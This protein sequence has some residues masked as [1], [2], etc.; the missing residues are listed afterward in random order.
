M[1]FGNVEGRNGEGWVGRETEKEGE[2][3]IDWLQPTCAPTGDRIEP[4]QAVDW[5]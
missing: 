2:L 4:A 1:I 5:I 3:D